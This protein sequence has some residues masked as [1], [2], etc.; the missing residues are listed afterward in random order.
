MNYYASGKL[1]LFGEYLVLKGSSCLAA[2]VK[3]GQKMEVQFI[4]GNYSNWTSRLQ[5][6]EWFSARFKKTLTEWETSDTSTAALLLKL[7]KLIQSEKPELFRTALHIKTDAD[8]PLEWGFGS[9]STLI[10]LLA[11][12]SSL[13]P[14]F[15]LRK[16]IGGSGFDVACA[17]QRAPIL[18]CMNGNKVQPAHLPKSITSKLLFV[19][20]GKKQNSANEIKRFNKLEIQKE[21]ILKM[22]KIVLAVAQSKQIDD[23][24]KLVIESE[25]LISGIL[26][27]PVI[28]ENKCKDYPFTLKSLGAW[29]GDFFMATYRNEKEARDYFSNLGY[30]IQFNYSQLIKN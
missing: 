29:G 22:D 13:D 8:F 4:P 26:N 17:L 1:I 2:P 27:S 25:D 10:S 5:G 23:F 21:D 3:Y 30:S 28:K 12:W 14:Y 11:Q 16:S 9:S 15:L 20:S 19:Y 18:Y 24:E 6:K 7:L